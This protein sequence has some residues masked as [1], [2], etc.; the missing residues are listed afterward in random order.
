VPA[1]SRHERLPALLLAASLAATVAAYGRVLPGEFQFDDERNIERNL[2]VKEPG[3]LASPEAW[4][5]A[6]RPLTTVTFAANYAVGAL[7]PVGYHATNLALHLAA[8]LLVFL[9][10]RVTA[11]SAG[12]ESPSAVAAAVASLF[13]LHPLQTESV[14]YVVQRSETLASL[15]YLGALLLLLQ[16]ERQAA[17]WR[18][19]LTYGGGLVAAAAALAAKPVAATLPLAYLLHAQAFP[20]P[21]AARLRLGGRLLRAAPLLALS[22]VAAWQGLHVS[23]GSS[24]AGLAIPG[25]APVEYVLTQGRV[26]FRYLSLLTLPVGQNVD[27]DV[28]V[29]RSLLEPGT[30][31]AALGLVALAVASV[32]TLWR[33]VGGASGRWSGVAR[34]SAFGF[35]W[36][37]LVLLPS[38]LVPL[39]DV[40]AEH[41]AY[42][43]SWGVLLAAVAAVRAAADDLGLGLPAR[44]AA[45]AAVLAT[46]AAATWNRNAVWETKVAL[47]SDAAE[48]SPAKPRPFANLAW[49]LSLRDDHARALGPYERALR[50]GPDEHLRAEILRNLGSTLAQM[51][52]HG[53]AAAALEEAAADPDV[54]ADARSLLAMSLV[55]RRLLDAAA[56]QVRRAL[57]I[58][59]DHG[60]ARNTLGQILLARQDPAAALEQFRI[61][62]RLDPDVPERRFNVALSLERLGRVEEACAAWREYLAIA[63]APAGVERAKSHMRQLGCGR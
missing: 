18:A 57:Q 53:E 5:L 4:T 13:A 44:T 45:L 59:P 32:A 33:R 9:L 54:E 2:D 21:E 55:E 28:A 30:L 3:R 43:A 50:L 49:S 62:V 60:A 19:A 48:K 35:L 25:L 46:L 29:S 42:L 61:A 40:M 17:A 24:H 22:S 1:P 58:D 34:V 51:G 6:K 20:A 47:W 8:A 27:P 23:S 39:A 10:T 52:R 41:R 37:L 12:L 16:A 31:A 38:S 26:V 56:E 63:R 14:S 15:L 11:R 7:G 36:F